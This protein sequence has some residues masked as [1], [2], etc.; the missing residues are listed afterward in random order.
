MRL[1]GV[2]PLSPRIILPRR[3]F[4]KGSAALAAYAALEGRADGTVPLGF[5]GAAASAP[6]TPASLPGLSLWLD[7]SNAASITSSGG[8]VSQWNDLSGNGNN[9]TQSVSGAKPNIATAVAPSGLNAMYFVSSPTV[10]FFNLA[11]TINLDSAGYTLFAVVKRVST[12]RIACILGSTLSSGNKYYGLWYSD[13]YLYT[14][15]QSYQYAGTT[16]HAVSAYETIT[17]TMSSANVGSSYFNASLDSGGTASSS[18]T[19]SIA[20]IASG[21]QTAY[22]TNAYFGEIVLCSGVLSSGNISATQAYLK[23]KWGTP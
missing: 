17:W 12:V 6:F 5:W 22:N 10:Q 20:Y 2:F 8:A 19:G 3:Q 15:N 9:V 16:N 11:S 18:R 14:T 23:A 7:A 4:L 21:A 1:A 13:S